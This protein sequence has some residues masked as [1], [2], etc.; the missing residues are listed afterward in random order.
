MLRKFVV[1]LV[2]LLR[3][4]DFRA[5]I[6]RQANV[7]VRDARSFWRYSK[8]YAKEWLEL[9]YG[10][11]TLLYDMQDINRAIERLG[12]DERLRIIK[13]QASS[14]V[15]ST[16][17]RTHTFAWFGGT[18]EVLSTSQ[19]SLSARG[20]FAAKASVSPI[21]QVNPV[22]TG[23]ELITFS[24]VIDW[25]FSVGSALKAMSAVALA[26]ESTGCT[27][28]QVLVERE[29]SM[30]SI[31]PYG[32][33]SL[34]MAVSGKAFAEYVIRSPGDPSYA[35]RLNLNLSL[36]KLADLLAL[37]RVAMK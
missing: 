14:G 26:S 32:G 30:G 29:P 6:A 25:V 16:D 28:I 33:T 4:P 35:P 19:I 12:A 3:D 9:R 24:F 11:R 36:T 2:K 27:G 23:W 22:V 7:A 17:V 34:S 5:Q 15:I 8:R 20:T 1:R 18:L 10:W 13:R 37:L 31:V 21:L